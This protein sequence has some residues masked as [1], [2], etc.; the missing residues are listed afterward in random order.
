[1]NGNRSDNRLCNLRTTTR[2]ENAQN[3]K[4][5]SGFSWEGYRNKW[6]TIVSVDKQK[7]TIGYY[8]TE[9]DARAAYL[10]AKREL[11]PF[12]TL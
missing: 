1:M 9:L 6:R 12:S 5:D 2:T 4:G 7:T 10:R 8:D 3:R 11:H